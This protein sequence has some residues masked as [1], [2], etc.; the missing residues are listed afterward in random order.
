M[1]LSHFES[2]A[3]TRGRANSRGL[4]VLVRFLCLASNEC[5]WNRR[6]TFRAAHCRAESQR[7]QRRQRR[8]RCQFGVQQ[9]R[10]ACACQRHLLFRQC[11]RGILIGCGNGEGTRAEPDRTHIDGVLGV[12]NP[13]VDPVT[14]VQVA[15]LGYVCRGKL[16]CGLDNGLRRG[17]G[18]PQEVVPKGVQLRRGVAH[19]KSY[20]VAAVVA[21]GLSLTDARR[22]V[23]GLMK[24]PNK[25]QQPRQVVRF[26]VLIGRTQHPCQLKR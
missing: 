15:C 22:A 21:S 2:R 19:G 25:V 3:G 6:A 17:A 23:Q 24:I 20:Q 18:W 13:F 14:D 12:V 4:S 5:G 11:L 1:A 8:Q 16:L 10:Q 7:C 26:Q 9:I